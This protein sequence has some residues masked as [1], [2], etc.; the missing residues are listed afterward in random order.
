MLAGCAGF[1]APSPLRVDL[2]AACESVLMP[3]KVPPPVKL[4]DDLGAAVA[5]RGAALKTANH[6]ITAGHDCVADQRKAYG[7]AR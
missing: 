3:V 2:P 7:A 5:R 1:N 4:G 6:T